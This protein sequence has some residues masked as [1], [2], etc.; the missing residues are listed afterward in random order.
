M[1]KFEGSISLERF[2]CH[3]DDYFVCFVCQNIVID[4]LE[5][6]NCETLACKNCIQSLNNCSACLCLLKTRTTSKY[7]IFYY[8][9]LTLKCVNYLN[10]CEI[11][12]TIGDVLMH[13]NACDYEMFVC[14]SS[15]CKKRQLK[16][17]K[18]SSNPLVCTEMCQ[19]L[20]EFDK[21]LDSIDENEILNAFH[22][23]LQDSKTR[24]VREMTQ[25]IRKEIEEL[26]RELE[27]KDKFEKE[28]ESLMQELELRKENYHPG[29]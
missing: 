5:C 29:K 8:N 15:I 24:V 13:E 14:A 28:E 11:E 21:I 25:K 22:T 2:T 19:K 26:D 6:S 18:Y 10:G 27:D 4:P 12:G 9:K 16:L 3:V 23:H 20:V 7:A 17:D 1:S